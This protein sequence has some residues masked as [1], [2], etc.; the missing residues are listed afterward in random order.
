V[1]FYSE[2]TRVI[3]H[4]WMSHSCDQE[5]KNGFLY[6]VGAMSITLHAPALCMGVG[7]DGFEDPVTGELQHLVGA[8]TG[9]L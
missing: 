6:F 2:K 4:L 8:E 3:A 5:V 7:S 1:E 9:H